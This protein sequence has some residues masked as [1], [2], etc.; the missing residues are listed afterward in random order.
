MTFI[1]GRRSNNIA[2]HYCAEA[3]STNELLVGVTINYAA[4]VH[5]QTRSIPPPGGLQLS[6]DDDA[7]SS[8][9]LVVTLSFAIFRCWELLVLCKASP[10]DAGSVREQL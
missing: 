6:Q 7:T 5:L 10:K 9:F 8:P 2:I 3:L 4:T 1:L